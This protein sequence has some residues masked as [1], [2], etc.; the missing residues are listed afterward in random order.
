VIVCKNRHEISGTEDPD[1]N[2]YSYIYLIFDKSAQNIRWRKNSLF[3][4]VIGKPGYLHTKNG[5]EIHI[6]HP[7]QLK[8]D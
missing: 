4:N 5:N 2:P 6:F 3:S 7:H 1:I 8:V